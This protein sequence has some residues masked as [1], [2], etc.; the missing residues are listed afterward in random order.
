[1][2][3][4]KIGWKKNEIGLWVTWKPFCRSI[5]QGGCGLR[6]S[7]LSGNIQGLH[8]SRTGWNASQSYVSAE[9]AAGRVLHHP[10]TLVA[11][12][13]LPCIS[14]DRAALP[15]FGESSE[16]GKLRGA[17]GTDSGI[18][19]QTWDV[20]QP[21]WNKG[22]SCPTWGPSSGAEDT[23][24]QEDQPDRVL[25]WSLHQEFG[26]CLDL[27]QE[28]KS[29]QVLPAAVLS[30][31]CCPGPWLF[32]WDPPS[33]PLFEFEHATNS[34]GAGGQDEWELLPGQSCLQVLD[35]NHMPWSFR[36]RGGI[37]CCGK[38]S[39]RNLIFPTVLYLGVQTPALE[40]LP[41]ECSFQIHFI[42]KLF[43][44]EH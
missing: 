35:L 44:K 27:W 14:R 16:A 36:G 30:P 43:R 20:P 21:Q 38:F 34:E 12:G 8:G 6:I 19:P 24:F 39:D 42:L 17:A 32:N 25:G 28:N 41:V 1:M 2:L 26:K 4:E 18:L 9:V 37:T 33:F 40:G 29:C 15:G 31:G 11:E 13:Q 3:K 22:S 5:G 7:R 23:H 10:R